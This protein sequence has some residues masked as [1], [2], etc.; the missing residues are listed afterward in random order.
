V[1]A[2]AY[3]WN[4]IEEIPDDVTVLAAREGENQGQV[5]AVKGGG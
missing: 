2:W 5:V 3:W 4:S 1:L